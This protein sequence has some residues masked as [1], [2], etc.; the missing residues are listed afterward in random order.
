MDTMKI[1]DI[2]NTEPRENRLKNHIFNEVRTINLFGE[3]NNAIEETMKSIGDYEKKYSK[4]SEGISSSENTF[5]KIIQPKDLT[6]SQKENSYMSSYYNIKVVSESVGT[7]I[8]RTI[9][10]IDN[11]FFNITFTIT[12]EKGN[13]IPSIVTQQIQKIID[14]SYLLTLNVLLY[15]NKEELYDL[16]K[17]EQDKH[18]ILLKNK[19]NKEKIT[20]INEVKDNNQWNLHYKIKDV[21]LIIDTSIKKDIKLQLS[22]NRNF[23]DYILE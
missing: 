1:I 21:D 12:N 2:N 14:K 9:G 18:I 10:K 20:E 15:D 8:Y 16:L 3:I 23:Y 11:R 13:T 22:S 5:Y 17:T 6:L 19:F 7:E 4:G